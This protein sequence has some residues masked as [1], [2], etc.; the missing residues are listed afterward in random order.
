MIYL[1]TDVLG[2]VLVQEINHVNRIEFIGR[3]PNKTLIGKL[4][5]F[6]YSSRCK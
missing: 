1:E 5:K 3:F 2:T 4:L 6:L